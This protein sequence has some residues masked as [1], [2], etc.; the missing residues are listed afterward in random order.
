MLRVHGG[1]ERYYHDEIGGNFRIDALQ[2]AVLRVKLRRLESW[3]QGR[4]NNAALYRRLFTES[5]LVRKGAV[6]PD[7]DAPVVLPDE[8]SNGRHIYNQFVIRAES[9]DELQ[10][11]LGSQ[12]VG[13]AVYYPLSLHM[14][15]CFADLGGRE[16][17]FPE[18]ERAARETLA[19]P[20]YP[21][22]SN[23]QLT[24]VVSCVVEFYR[25][26]K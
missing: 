9:R 16:G 1:I 5:G 2:S 21:E 20:I 6:Y 7:S 15:K 25:Q 17:D 13:C 22:L 11:F 3:T 18:S 19:L 10:R 12:N 23:K 24:T 4:R 26:K 8:P 14:Q